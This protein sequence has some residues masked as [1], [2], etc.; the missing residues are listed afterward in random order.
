MKF[1]TLAWTKACSHARNVALSH[2]LFALPFAYMALMLAAEGKPSAATVFW[3]TLAMVTARS[4]ALAINNLIDLRYDKKQPR[5]CR[6][7]LVTGEIKK[8]ECLLFIVLCLGVFF[9]SAAKLHPICIWLSP[10]ALLFF[11]VYP[12][13]KRFSWTCHLVLGLTLALAPLAAWVAVRGS[14]DA[15]IAVLAIAVGGWIAGF[16]IVYGCLDVDF[17]KKNGLHSIPEHFGVSKALTVSRL[18]HLASVAG[19][20]I[21]GH[22]FGLGLLF[23]GGITFAAIILYYQ[24]R[25]VR[26][27]DLT[28]VTQTY[29]LRNGLVGISLFL[30]T[31]LSVV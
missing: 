17:D 24:H 8:A 23:Y 18:F 9:W 13:M 22:L 30:F 11:V 12:Y 25:I 3:V 31:F 5:F 19:F 20:S 14:V 7:P 2:S 26:A 27:E 10:I 28:R 1:W 21:A 29:F 15:A 16:D 4:A 6:R